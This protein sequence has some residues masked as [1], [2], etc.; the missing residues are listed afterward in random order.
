MLC[1]WDRD[2]WVLIVLLF[3]ACLACNLWHKADAIQRDSAFVHVKG[4]DWWKDAL[5][6]CVRKEKDTLRLIEGLGVRDVNTCS[7][8]IYKCPYDVL[9]R[10]LRNNF[11]VLIAFFIVNVWTSC[12]K[13]QKWDLRF[14]IKACRLILMRRTGTFL[15]G[16]PKD[17]EWHLH[18]LLRA[19][20]PSNDTWKQMLIQC[21]G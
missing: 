3:C 10:G 1:W 2:Q 14:C 8:F 15:L 17:C 9:F 13:T 6:H 7:L 19:S 5:S 12:Y 21:S 4:G 20:L 16:K 18:T 11:H